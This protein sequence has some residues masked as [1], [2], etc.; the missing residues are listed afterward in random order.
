MASRLTAGVLFLMASSAAEIPP[1]AK[2]IDHREVRHEAT[3]VDPYF[4]LRDKK[5]PEVTR[6]LEAENAYTAAMTKDVQPFADALYKE[7]L[8]HIRQTD[9]SVPVRRGAYLYYSRTEE[10]KQY[11]ILC[12]R[13][14][15]AEAPEEVM[16]DLN[17]LA[18]GKKFLSVGQSEVSD[19]A[20]L[21]AYTL[22]DTGYRQYKLHVKDLRTGQTLS[23]TA[24]RVTSIE[25]ATDN[26][27]LFY[28]TE[29]EVT[30]RSDRL[31]RHP[32]GGATSELYHEK[33][34]LYHIGLGRTRDKKFLVL[35][36]S[37]TI[38]KK[39]GT[40]AAAHS[41][42]RVFLPREEA[43]LHIDHREGL[44]YIRTDNGAKDSA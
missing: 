39:P 34:E 22:D 4:W 33:D 28:V 7:M 38:M 43:P 2:R 36:I 24:E 8:S 6:Y 27:T 29:D 15:T 41:R 16:L 9:L 19:D 30:K 11:P 5:N 18:Q 10:G 25:W 17:Q 44:F 14:D 26:K 31:W 42:W 23:D 3:L 21:L 35:E 37:S 20:N 32:L 40:E 12:R 13:K 1:I